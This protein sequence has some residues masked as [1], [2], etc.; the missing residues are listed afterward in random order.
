MTDDIV[1]RDAEPVG[2]AI[3]PTYRD[4]VDALRRISTDR[5]ACRAYCPESVP[6]DIIRSVVGIARHTAS[7]C[8]VQPWQV[9]VASA[10]TTAAFRM[11][12]M[13]R[14]RQ[15]SAISSDLE[16]P[17][18]YKGIY[19]ERRRETGYQLYNALGIGREDRER[20][21]EQA[22]EN[23]RMFGAPHV[24]I[25]SVPAEI[26]PYGLVDCGAFIGNF[27]AAATAHGLATT[28][29]AA[30]A[31]HAPLIHEF[32]DIG[33]EHQ[34]VCGIAFGYADATHPANGFR[35]RRADV[36]EIMHMV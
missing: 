31:R 27:L 30:I 26:G 10:E 3:N 2:D 7:W 1:R 28:P 14:A 33:E 29:Q 15:T 8:N 17:P 35:T 20:R 36:D 34:V 32:F 19:K 23:F 18:E 6:H 11:T 24:A 9:V 13:R 5:F 4:A 21:E 12:L 16:F 25:I 22:F